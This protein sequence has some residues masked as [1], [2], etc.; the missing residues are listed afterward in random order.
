MTRKFSS[1]SVETALQSGIN[2][3]TTTMTVTAGTGTTLM[4]GVS[5]SAGNVDQFTLA[6]A[7]DTINEEIV[8]VTAIAADTLTIQRAK[9]GT[10][11][12]THSAGAVVKHV[13]TSDDLNYFTTGV[14]AAVTLTGTQTLTNKTLTSPGIS[15]ISNTGTI[16]LPTSSDTLV[17][18]AT[19]DTL[20]NKTMS[21]TSN[22]LT[23][24]TAQ[25][26]TAL[27]DGDFATLAGT[28][29]LSG[30]TLTSPAEN[31]PTLKSPQEITTVSATAATG[32]INFDYLTQAILYYTTNASANFTFNFRGNSSTTLNSLM[33]T[34][35]SVTV[36]FLNTNGTTAYYPTAIAIDGT[37]ITP[38]WVNGQAPTVGNASSIDA[39]SYTII[40][41]SSTPT[42]VVLATQNKFA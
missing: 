34:G 42:Y 25:F 31:Y 19:T 36:T 16:T 6:I 24:T 15:T 21:L 41:T 18:R 3:S 4:G 1:V 2:S 27:S 8:F 33:D 23:G 29:T 10:S 13:L 5:L 12:Q 39:Y 22:T 37:S 11:G 14:D 40:K 9:A 30:K 26:N 7:P 38:K 28:E 35:D 20:T 32:T 17:G